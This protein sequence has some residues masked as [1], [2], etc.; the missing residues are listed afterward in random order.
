MSGAGEWLSAHGAAV[1]ER[2]IQGEQAKIPM[3][4]WISIIL[5]GYACEDPQFYEI[6]DRLRKNIPDADLIEVAD[7][8]VTVVR[9]QSVWRFAY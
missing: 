2:F 8:V 9:G 1:I 3:L 6:K 5:A 4:D 7:D